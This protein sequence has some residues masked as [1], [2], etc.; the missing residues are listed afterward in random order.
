MFDSSSGLAIYITKTLKIPHKEYYDMYINHSNRSCFFCG[1]EGKFISVSKGYRNLCENQDCVKKSFH[2]NSVEGIMFRDMCNREEAQVK[3]EIEK[4]LQLEKRIE[5]CNK[6]RQIDPLWD[7]KRSR[8]CK[9]FWLKKGFSEEEAIMKK[10]EVMS[11]IHE[12][13][14]KKVLMNPEKYAYKHTTKIEYYLKKGY[15]IEE[16]RKKL[17]ERQSTF[18]KKICINKYGE[19]Q[20]LKIFNERQNKWLTTLSKKT[21]EE[22]L[23]INRKKI[24]T[25]P[26]SS[27]SQ[28]LFWDIYKS[29]GNTQTRFAEL[30]KE[31]SLLNEKNKAFVFDYVDLLRKKC[32]EFNGDF[33]HCNP[34]T[35]ESNYY[36]SVKRMS[37]EEIWKYDE[38][39]I[40]FLKKDGFDVLVV[41]EDDYKKYP[42][43]IL[44]KCIEFINN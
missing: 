9:E 11:E 34:S 44:E 12:K 23:E 7:K 1:E 15:N 39:K 43:Q 36:H 42:K 40:E 20:G 28:K 22:K 25:T 31:Y 18:S 26:Y 37:A 3:Y 30:N 35:F 32:I 38:E 24:L 2:S 10:N 14:F 4:K 19:E 27:I 33:W 5:T 41:W 8:N 21:E 13:T 16:A 6:I 29:V 17:S